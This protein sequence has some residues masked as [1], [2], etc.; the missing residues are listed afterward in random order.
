VAFYSFKISDMGRSVY[1]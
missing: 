1:R